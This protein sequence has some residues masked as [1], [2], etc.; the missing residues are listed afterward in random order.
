MTH[1]GDYSEYCRTRDPQI[2]QMKK[3][4]WTAVAIARHFG[5][6]PERIRQVLHGDPQKQRRNKQAV[7][8]AAMIRSQDSLDMRWASDIVV[9]VLGL[10]GWPK[11]RISLFFLRRTPRTISLRELM[12]LVLPYRFRAYFRDVPLLRRSGIGFGIHRAVI[13]AMS[14]QDFGTHFTVEWKRRVDYYGEYWRNLA[15]Q[16][17]PP[18][19]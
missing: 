2:V 19:R 16:P 18:S 17:G 11:K 7:C 1:V 6:S 8:L 10:R 15:C 3:D 5:R 14:S 13:R 4:G 12:D 9:P